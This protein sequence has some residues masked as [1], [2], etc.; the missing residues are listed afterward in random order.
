MI[1]RESPVA[2]YIFKAQNMLS[3]SFCV[4]QLYW[5]TIFVLLSLN[6]TTTL[7]IWEKTQAL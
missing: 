2:H 6:L 5:L 1:R 7:K 4:S 3:I